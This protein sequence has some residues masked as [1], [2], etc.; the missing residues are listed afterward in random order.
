MICA[1]RGGGLLQA[2]KSRCC[3]SGSEPGSILFDPKGRMW[4]F[5][6]HLVHSMLLS[7]VSVDAVNF[8]IPRNGIV[9]GLFLN[10]LTSHKILR[11]RVS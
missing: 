6:C 8:I 3:R 5:G 7:F 9:C 4:A 11:N 1:L 2:E 10:F